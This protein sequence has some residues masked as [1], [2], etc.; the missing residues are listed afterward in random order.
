MAPTRFGTYKK[1]S[2]SAFCFW[3]L[4]ATPG[5]LESPHAL[6]KRIS[7]RCKKDGG[8]KLKI[9]PPRAPHGP[10]SNPTH[11]R[12]SD[13][14]NNTKNQKISTSGAAWCA[15]SAEPRVTKICTAVNMHVLR[16]TANFHCARKKC[17]PAG[18]PA[19]A[20]VAKL[21]EINVK[22]KMVRR[23]AK[24]GAAMP[25]LRARVPMIHFPGLGSS[26]ATV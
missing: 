16:Q 10:P 1:A 13:T 3:T 4:R 20:G 7:A 25:F 18:S 12:K 8:K 5:I 26:W 14:Q 15:R 24:R 17:I 2:K 19:G 6:P 9:D 21:G 22:I 23:A 11:R